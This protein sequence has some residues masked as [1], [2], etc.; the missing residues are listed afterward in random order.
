[1]K[2]LNEART[3][4]IELREK[5]SYAN[6]E[7]QKHIIKLDK[8][9]RGAVLVKRMHIFAAV[10]CIIFTAFFL[11]FM[12]PNAI[13][14]M[15]ILGLAGGCYALILAGIILQIKLYN[16]TIK[17]IKSAIAFEKVADKQEDERPVR[18]E[19]N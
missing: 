17:K 19:T 15:I 12:Y 8:I 13:G 16:H 5:L 6:L 2:K 1:M 4:A 18:F 11:Y 10:F 3:K 14:I 7:D 9:V